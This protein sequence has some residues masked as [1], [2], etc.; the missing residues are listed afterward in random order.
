MRKLRLDLDEL[1]VESFHVASPA[2]RERGTV[3]GAGVQ[4]KD[5]VPTYDEQCTIE[6]GPL[7]CSSIPPTPYVPCSGGIESWCASNA[8]NC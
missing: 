3:R 6:S 4:Y 2:Q 1:E 5:P 7:L 8:P